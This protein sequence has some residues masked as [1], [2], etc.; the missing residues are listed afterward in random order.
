MSKAHLIELAQE[1]MKRH[2]AKDA[3]GIAS[4]FAQQGSI[5]CWGTSSDEEVHSVSEL[6]TMVQLDYDATQSLSLSCGDLEVFHTENSGVVF[7]NW[8][9]EYQLIGENMTHELMLRTTLYAEKVGEK[10][11]IRHAHWS[12][13]ADNQTLAADQPIEIERV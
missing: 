8:K 13:A 5:Q 11:Q 7:G 12:V 3:T 6:A 9:A 2:S 10:W 4:L 1:Y